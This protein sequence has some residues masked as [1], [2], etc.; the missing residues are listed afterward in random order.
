[1]E[2]CEW[3]VSCGYKVELDQPVV[4][5][6]YL[7]LSGRRADSHDGAGNVRCFL[8]PIVRNASFGGMKG[9]A[10][11]PHSSIPWCKLRCPN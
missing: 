4:G 11:N 7:Y 8:T 1:M 2:T 9:L 6:K 3:L 5:K 10:R